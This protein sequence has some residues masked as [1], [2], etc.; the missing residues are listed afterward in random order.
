MAILSLCSCS[1]RYAADHGNTVTPSRA[2]TAANRSEVELASKRISQGRPC[3][4]SA[5]STRLRIELGALGITSGICAS[6]AIET[7][8]ELRANSGQTIR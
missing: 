5:H 6:S 8:F 7:L 1:S 2:I 3:S 4:R